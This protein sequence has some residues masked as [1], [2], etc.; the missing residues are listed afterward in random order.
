[1][2]IY[3]V[4]G[5]DS[6]NIRTI[7]PGASDT[8]SVPGDLTVDGNMTVL[9]TTTTINSEVLTADRFMLMNS[10]YADDTA[11]DG[12]ICWVVDP[13]TASYSVDNSA[14]TATT[15]VI[16]ADVTG[17]LSANDFILVT[18]ATDSSNNGL[19]EIHSVSYSSG[20]SK[21]TITIKDASTNTP[22]SSIEGLVLTSLTVN[23]DDD[24]ITVTKVK[25]G[26]LKTDAATNKMLV[27]FGD[28]AAALSF[29]QMLTS[30]D[31]ITANSMA[32]DDLTIGDSAVNLTTSVGAITIDSNAATVS[33][34]GHTG[35]SI[36]ASN[37][38]DVE[39]ISTNFVKIANHNGSSQGLKLG[40]ALVT[41]TA[42]E[43][44]LLDGVTSTTAELNILDGVTATAAELN[45]LDGVTSTAAELNIL[46]GVTASTAELNKLDGVT[47]S[48]AELN[49]LDG[50]TASTDELNLLDG[51][52]STTAELNILDGVTAT[53]AELNI[54]DGVTATAAELNILDGVTSTAAELNILDGVTS[55]AA[56][57]NKLDGVDT[58]TSELN[59]LNTSSAGAINNS[60]AVIYGSAGQVNATSLQLSGVNLTAS[61][62]EFNKLTGLTASTSE[63]NI[64]DGVTSTAAELNILDGVTSTAAEINKLD[65]LT[66]STAELNYV[67]VTTPGQAENSKALVVDG[68]KDLSGL[69]NLETDKIHR[70]GDSLVVEGENGLVFKENNAAV[71]SITDSRSVDIEANASKFQA[72]PG[73]AIQLAANGYAA[74]IYAGLKM[75]S[76]E[77]YDSGCCLRID[78]SN[79]KTFK[80]SSSSVS[81]SI[82]FGIAVEDA[83]GADQS[84]KVATMQGSVVAF[85]FANAVANGVG[86]GQPIFLDSSSND[87]MCTLTA[88]TSGSIV[89]VG[90]LAQNGDGSATVLTGVIQIRN[91]LTFA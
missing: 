73:G 88:P 61:A 53:A 50:V 43:L 32:S 56:E 44:N 24:T 87:G 19:Y 77:A 12:G 40:N 10:N 9:G 69:R 62:A 1:M 81:D 64:L 70:A 28:D 89:Q 75:T 65:G 63:L 2:T 23:S 57:L 55:T 5:F 52:T 48:T 84:K 3:K 58:T 46:D 45:I 82:V 39:L 35:V 78:Q 67:D 42:A 31:S 41:A 72:N 49:L 90:I 17:S 33:I 22:T 8:L 26:I 76:G 34:D 66:A 15:I 36:S 30:A 20:T 37:Q 60:K 79:G 38:G 59:L 80:A 25:V 27:A 83:S 47:A 14:T 29:G 85:K 91:I 16:P 6:T 21:S 86:V 18:S 74:G 13:T 71:I 4:T 68:N 7:I 51:V 54:L 11:K